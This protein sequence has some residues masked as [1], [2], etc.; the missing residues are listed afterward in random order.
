MGKHKPGSPEWQ[1]ALNAEIAKHDAAE[2]A[3]NEAAGASD[4]DI[5]EKIPPKDEK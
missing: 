4:Q 3:R 2:K 5:S 1:A